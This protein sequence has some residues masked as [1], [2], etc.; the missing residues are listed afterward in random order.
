MNAWHYRPA[1]DLDKSVSEHLRE[2]PRQPRMLEYAI[3]G[4]AAMFLRLWMRLYHRL[5]ID[6][7]DN[8][9]RNGSFVLVCNHASHLD[10]L[11]MLCAM[12][13]RSIHR[14]FPAAASDYFFSNLPR[15]AISAVLI[16]ALPFDRKQG[17]ARSLESCAELLGQDGNI[18]ILF[19]EGTRTTNGDMSRFRSGI[20]RLVASRPWPV[21]P[22]YLD[23]AY[24]A[25]PKGRAFPRPKRLRLT[26]GPAQHFDHIEATA[27]G[28]DDIC[29][30]LERAVA[31]LGEQVR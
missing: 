12:P 31:S 9:P 23:G 7:R 26:I 2:F 16:N 19:P 25:W 20:G 13:V 17:G 6:G 14:V 28:V 27:S 10:T 15:S 22:C 29:R 4:L 18:L 5:R 11:A 21:V 1:P 8:L 3:R 30:S 24:D